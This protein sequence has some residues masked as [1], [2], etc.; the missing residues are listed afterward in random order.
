MT[1]LPCVADLGGIDLQAWLG[2]KNIQHTVRYTEL[3]PDRFKD[4][5][6]W[7]ICGDRRDVG[8]GRSRSVYPP[9][10]NDSGLAQGPA[11]ASRAC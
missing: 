5:W 8:R 2:H 11:G 9:V 10:Q 6:R 1:W 7:S 4:F 3:A